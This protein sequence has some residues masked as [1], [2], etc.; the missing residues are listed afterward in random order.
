MVFDLFKEPL[1]IR[2]YL[3]FGW[4]SIPVDTDVILNMVNNFNQK[5]VSFPNCDQRPR[6]LPIYSNDALRVA[7]SRHSYQLDLQNI[8]KILETLKGRKLKS[9][10]QLIFVTALIQQF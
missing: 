4:R 3:L 6:K 2:N 1:H 10:N 9:K 7:Q 8:L 5:I